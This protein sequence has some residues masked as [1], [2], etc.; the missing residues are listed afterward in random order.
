MPE[1]SILLIK[2]IVIVGRVL[3]VI[4]CFFGIFGIIKESFSLSLVF[5]CLHVH[6]SGRHAIRALL[7]QRSRIHGTDMHRDPSCLSFS[8]PSSAARTL[9]QQTPSPHHPLPHLCCRKI[10]KPVTESKSVTWLFILVLQKKSQKQYFS[11][12]RDELIV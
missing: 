12:V 8:C 10:W 11:T 1:S 2:S 4:L 9:I 7:Q 3:V 6:S 5:R